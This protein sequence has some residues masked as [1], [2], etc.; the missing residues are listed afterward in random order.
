MR[1]RLAA[2][3]AGAAGVGLALAVAEVLAAAIDGVPSLVTTVSSYVIP[4]VPPAVE[5]VVIGLFGTSDKAVLAAGTVTLSLLI[6]AVAGILG[7]TNRSNATALF[8]MF[9]MLGVLA[10]LARP[11]TAPVATIVVTVLATVAGRRPRIPAHPPP[12]PR[13]CA[14]TR[15]YKR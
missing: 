15:P 11:L 8:T 9:G 5:D 1:A 4:F 6:G 13:E 7:M 14:L 2:G 10:A 12:T 3:S